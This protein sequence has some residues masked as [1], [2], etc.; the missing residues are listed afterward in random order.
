MNDDGRG[1]VS[2]REIAVDTQIIEDVY[3]KIIAERGDRSIEAVGWLSEESALLV[4]EGI[5]NLPQQNWAELQTVL[6][7]GSGQGYFLSFLREKRGFRGKYIGL[8]LLPEFDRIARD[9]YSND[10]RSEFICAEFLAYPFD[11]QKFD[12]IISIGSLG[13]RQPDG[14]AFD[15]AFTDKIARFANR[16]FSLYLNDAK[17][18]NP[19]RLEERPDLAVHNV[20][21]F[22][23]DLEKR[24]PSCWVSI[25]HCPQKPSQ[26]AIIHVVL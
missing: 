23:E 19:S 5:S 8:E 26:K 12:W 22:A 21:Q 3:H 20:E 4:Y 18:T 17:Y 9:V 7:I 2:D 11:S 14:D 15:R 10:P 6:D 13:L 25:V 16:G 1:A 24:F